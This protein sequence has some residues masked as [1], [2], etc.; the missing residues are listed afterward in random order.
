MK[1]L[2]IT[3]F[4]F[5]SLFS[6]G[7]NPLVK[8]RDKRYGGKGTDELTCFQQTT[9]GGY[10][11]GGW[12][13]SGI[14]GDKS[15]ADW[16]TTNAKSSDYWIVKIDSFGNKQWD[17]RFG[18]TRWDYLYA[19]EQTSDG[20]Y[21]LGGQSESGM[22]G[23]KSQDAWSNGIWDYWVV[24]TDANGNKQWDRR[25]GGTGADILFT[26]DQ[27][28][29]EGYILG[30]YS[31]SGISGDKTEAKRDTSSGFG[32]FWVIKIDSSGNKQWDKSFGGAKSD[33]I[34]SA[35]QTSDN[36]FLLGGISNSPIGGDK[37]ES[38]RDTSSSVYSSYD[39][40]IIKTDDNG[41]KEWDKTFG[42]TSE[43]E[44]ECVIETSDQGFIASGVSQSDATGDKS[45]NSWGWFDYWI[46]KFNSSGNKEWDHDYGG[47]GNEDNPKG[48][49]C[50]TN[51]RGFLVAGTSYSQISGDKT[52]NNLA[53]E[54][55][56]VI[57]TDSLG[58]KQWDKT[59]FSEAYYDDEIGLAIQMR[60]GCYAFANYTNSNTGG[61]KSQD[62]WDTTKNTWDYWM[63]RFCDTTFR[64]SFTSN[65]TLCPGSCVDFLNLSVNAIN[66]QWN[67]PGASPDTSTDISPSNICYPN[68]GSY[69]V[70]LI[71]TNANGSDTLLLTNYITVF[72]TP[73][74]QSIT[75]NADTLFSIAGSANYQWYFNGNI[76]NGAT[77][78]FYVAP[79]SGDYNV[80]A[81][82][83]N[84]CEV[85]A[86]IF[87]V[88]AGLQST[89]DS[90]Q[91]MV[92]PNPVGDKLT[93]QKS[94]VT[95]ETAVEISIYNVWGVL[96]VQPETSN[97]K[98]ETNIDVAKL[99]P[100]LYYIEI[101]SSQKIFRTKFVKQ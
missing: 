38:N 44:L 55:T 49:I 39:F 40:W 94:Q 29:D 79:A 78:Y 9:D 77:D 25:Y 61:Y 22:N 99:P 66:Y 11:L 88:T 2:L 70:Q 56:W 3:F 7:Q 16:D 69:D 28:K 80:V 18:G 100:G 71:A 32:D 52:E 57:K 45:Q 101:I 24:K 73:P 81:T 14:G 85:E 62:N 93:I 64:A 31:A 20:G 87:N 59:V 15:Q 8:M 96:A 97:L 23:D 36:G 84:G 21:I 67:F 89:V 4:I 27:T 72:P 30:G 54:Q 53:S 90:Q 51:D 63:I 19:L 17:K 13:R 37:T 65:Q 46:V 82:D 76:I 58:N 91:L 34:V 83:S 74:Q 10:I 86:A 6:N 75:Q 1:H 35:I 12:S 48:S 42:G 41:N 92:F 47:T 60:D 95:R 68:P 26:L 43:D 33:W 50:E 5:C 98:L